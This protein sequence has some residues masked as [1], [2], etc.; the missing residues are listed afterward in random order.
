MAPA[1]PRQTPLF[2]YGAGHVS[3]ALIPRLDGL[4][5]DIFLIDIEAARFADDLVIMCKNCLPRNLK[6]L[7]FAP[8][9]ARFIWS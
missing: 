1:I 5:F 8:R 4:G 7:R 9:K 6:K 3:R 2:I